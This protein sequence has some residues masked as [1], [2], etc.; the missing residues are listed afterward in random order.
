MIDG[1]RR[2]WG[3]RV[4]LGEK[5]HRIHKQERQVSRCG[6]RVGSFQGRSQPFPHTVK[7]LGRDRR[8][9]GQ[10]YA[11]NS[12][13]EGACGGTQTIQIDQGKAKTRCTHLL[14]SLARRETSMVDIVELERAIR[15]G[16]D[17]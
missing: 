8:Q 14:A 17:K 9:P 15:G 1:A 12:Q 2:R 13:A 16:A 11:H 6:G 4:C 3:Q 5:A 7:Q 10:N